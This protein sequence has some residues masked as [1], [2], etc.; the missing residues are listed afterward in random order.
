[1]KFVLNDLP[2]VAFQDDA[3]A[4]IERT[5]TRTGT[6]ARPVTEQSV[7]TSYV[8]NEVHRLRRNIRLPSGL[9]RKYHAYYNCLWH[10]GLTGC[11]SQPSS[12]CQWTC[13]TQREQHVCHF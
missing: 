1:M 3:L 8:M 13:V 6:A 7:D 11:P 9:D 10:E 12:F 5:A 4:Q 2:F